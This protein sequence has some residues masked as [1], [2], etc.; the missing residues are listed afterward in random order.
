M[1]TITHTT[2]IAC[3]GTIACPATNDRVG[4]YN[5]KCSPKW[6]IPIHHCSPIHKSIKTHIKSKTA[7]TEQVKYIFKTEAD[8]NLLLIRCAHELSQSS[9][10][11]AVNFVAGSYKHTHPLGCT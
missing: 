10:L 5:L 1:A 4:N 7:A 8:S 9:Y 2:R 11:T 3:E 6:S